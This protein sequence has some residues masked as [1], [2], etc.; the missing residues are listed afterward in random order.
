MTFLFLI[1]LNFVLFLY[2][3]IRLEKKFQNTYTVF[4]TDKEGNRQRL[5]DTI[6][7]LLEQNEIQEKRL[8]YLVDEMA[9]QWDS[10]ELVKD[11]LGME[12]NDAF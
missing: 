6:A 5:S 10:I 3:K 9:K 11:T 12:D 2:I 4:L 8:L 7:Y 1:V